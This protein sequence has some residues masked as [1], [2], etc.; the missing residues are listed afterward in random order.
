M[1]VVLI[2]VLSGYL[3]EGLFADH[4]AVMFSVNNILYTYAMPLFFML[5]GLLFHMSRSAREDPETVGK[6]HIEGIGN[7][8]VVYFAYSIIYALL[9]ILLSGYV[10]AGVTFTD[11]ALIWACPIGPYWY[12]Y[13]LTGFYIIFGFKRIRSLPPKVMIIVLAAISAAVS[14]M[15]Q[16]YWF[17]LDRLAYYA[18][19]F[20]L[21]MQLNSVLMDR[22]LSIRWIPA[23]FAAV[24]AA[25]AVLFRGN[26]YLSTVPVVNVALGISVSLLVICLFRRFKLIRQ[27]GT[28]VF[29]GKH[30]LEI[31]LLHAF[32]VAACRTVLP[33]AGIT[34]VW[35]NILISFI[36]GL[37]IPLLISL[38]AEKLGIHKL[39]FKPWSFFADRNHR[40]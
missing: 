35:V 34:N 37:L 23:A 1:S 13:V 32:A 18:L 36:C 40:L 20:Y 2:H 4:T 14:F 39:L 27:S 3:D 30:T 26:G 22:M 12:L 7:F 6:K 8:A 21:G 28:L 33:K 29:C 15:P 25:L 19:F 31:Y 5:S 38:A 17:R 24:S 16:I 9:K 10:Y 11:L